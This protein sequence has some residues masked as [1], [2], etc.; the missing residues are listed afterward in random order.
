M[1]RDGEDG[2]DVGQ[3]CFELLRILLEAHF[4]Q[5]HRLANVL[6]GKKKGIKMLFLHK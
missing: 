4:C 1:H 6:D 5:H 2:L 3:H